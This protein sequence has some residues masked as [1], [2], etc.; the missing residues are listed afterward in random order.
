MLVG[1]A[2]YIPADNKL[3][4]AKYADAD[5]SIGV[6]REVTSRE[7]TDAENSI[8]TEYTLVVTAELDGGVTLRRHLT[9]TRGSGNEPEHPNQ[10][11]I[12]RRVRFRHNTLDPDDVYDEQFEGWP[13]Q[14]RKRGKK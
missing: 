11:W 10:S 7:T 12:G 14:E 9:T 5:S 3:T 13:D 6:V 8:V 4:R 2:V 1:L